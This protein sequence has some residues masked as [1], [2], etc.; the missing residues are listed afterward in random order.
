MGSEASQL[1]CVTSTLATSAAGCGNRSGSMAATTSR[2]AV[3]TTAQT[4]TTTTHTATQTRRYLTFFN[5]TAP[6]TRIV[7]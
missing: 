3:D 2:E 5:A 1:N 4:H 7:A 6:K